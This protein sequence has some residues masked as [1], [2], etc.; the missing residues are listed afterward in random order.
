MLYH[1]YVRMQSNDLVVPSIRNYLALARPWQPAEMWLSFVP[2]QIGIWLRT[3]TPT[4]KIESGS[5]DH[6]SCNFCS[7][8]CAVRGQWRT[9]WGIIFE[10]KEWIS[11][12]GRF[13]WK[14]ESWFVSK[15]ILIIILSLVRVSWVPP[16]VWEN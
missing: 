3:Q 7:R 12:I 11:D 1:T 8:Y 2:S 4:A 16:F 14:F 9:K 10:W 15:I 6:T 5:K 13:H